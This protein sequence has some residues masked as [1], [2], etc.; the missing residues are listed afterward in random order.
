[1]EGSAEEEWMGG[2][3]S[4]YEIKII[5]HRDMP[6]KNDDGTIRN[7]DA[8]LVHM[9]YESGRTAKEVKKALKKAAE[10]VDFAE[11]KL[12]SPKT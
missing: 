1:V 12:Q 4:K 7:K 9:S 10:S 11:A 3:M 5:I 6:A 8:D 2:G